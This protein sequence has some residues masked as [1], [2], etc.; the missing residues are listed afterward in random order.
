MGLSLRVRDDFEQIRNP[1][2][3]TGLAPLDYMVAM[4]LIA[5]AN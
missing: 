5:E 4:R 2:I 1:D 3:D